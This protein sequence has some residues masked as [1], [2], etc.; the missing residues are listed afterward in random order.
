MMNASIK[1]GLIFYTSIRVDVFTH[2][3]DESS[4]HGEGERVVLGEEADDAGED[5]HALELALRVL[6]HDAGPHLDL[7]AQ[8]QH[9]LQDRTARD[10][11]CDDKHDE[12]VLMPDMWSVPMPFYVCKR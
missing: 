11:A 8:L 4:W 10:T 7:I 2:H 3:A 6:R 5:G 1:A 9:A 12:D